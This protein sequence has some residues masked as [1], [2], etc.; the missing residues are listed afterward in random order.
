MSLTQRKPRPLT[1]DSQTLRDDRLFI[2]ACDDTYA[3]KQYFGFFRLIRVQVHVIPTTMGDS[4]AKHVLERLLGTECDIDDQLW[5]M[6]DTDHCIQEEHK[7]GFLQAISEARRRGVNIALSR[8]SFE[9][10]LLLHH[11]DDSDVVS[12]QNAEQ[13]E[14]KLREVLGEYNK[15]QLKQEH[16]PLS[17]VIRA[18]KRAEKLDTQVGGGDVPEQNTSRV[19]LLWRAIISEALASQLPAELLELKN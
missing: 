7:P 14:K 9:L 2:I 4:S 16:F 5:L 19:Y 18:Y 6:L 10:W 3:P 15:T 8:P 13:V 12:L 17:S 11:V 1:R